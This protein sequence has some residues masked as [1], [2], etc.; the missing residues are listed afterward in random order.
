MHVDHFAPQPAG[1]DQQQDR[2]DGEQELANSHSHAAAPPEEIDHIDHDNSEVDTHVPDADAF[3]R[4]GI[5]GEEV[6]KTGKGRY[7]SSDDAPFNCVEGAGA[8][9]YIAGPKHE[10]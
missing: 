3:N 6:E 1:N 2:D 9:E 4:G 10:D 5:H 7:K 8:P